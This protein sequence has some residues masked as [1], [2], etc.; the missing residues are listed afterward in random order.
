VTVLEKNGTGVDLEGSITTWTDK[1]LN[2]SPQLAA[3]TFYSLPYL[4][5]IKTTK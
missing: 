3:G 5:A 2:H 1:T 4:F